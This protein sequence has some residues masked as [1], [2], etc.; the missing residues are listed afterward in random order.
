MEKKNTDGST[1]TN[2][3]TAEGS[4]ITKKDAQGNTTSST[5]TNA[6]S[7]TITNGSTSTTINENGVSTNKVSVGDKTTIENG[8]ATIGGVTINGNGEND[9]SDQHTN[10][11]APSPVFPTRPLIQP[12]R[13]SM[14]TPAGPLRKPS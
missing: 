9:G 14:K 2:K 6:G 1:I 10:T 5:T 13:S 7:L 11:P 8:S 4:T 3:T 12:I